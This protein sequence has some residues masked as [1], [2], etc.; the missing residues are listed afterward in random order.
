MNQEIS[1]NSVRSPQ[2]DDHIKRYGEDSDTCF[3]C[4]KK[5][6][7]LLYVHYTTD[8]NLVNTAEHPNSQGLFPVGSKCAKKL[9]KSFIF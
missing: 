2:Y 9:P 1:L 6:P 5:T 3:L 8:G 4:G 7:E